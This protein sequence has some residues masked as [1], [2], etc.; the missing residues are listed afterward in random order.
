MDIRQD[1]SAESSSD[2]AGALS[3][4]NPFQLSSRQADHVAWLVGMLGTPAIWTAP[5]PLEAGRRLVVVATPP[6][7]PQIEQF[8]RSLPLNSVVVIPF[9]ENP[10]FDSL[11][12]KLVNYGTIAASGAEKPHVLWWGGTGSCDWAPIR[13]GNAPLVMSCFD[14]TSAEAAAAAAQLASSLTALGVDPSIYAPGT[15]AQTMYK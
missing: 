12:S 2:T 9:G 15:M 1:H 10:L 13:D 7:G 5:G 11:K 4:L 3:A 6:T 14:R 8:C